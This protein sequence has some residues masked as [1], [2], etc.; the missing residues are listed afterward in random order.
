MNIQLLFLFLS[1]SL[2]LLKTELIGEVNCNDA[3]IYCV[4]DDQ[5]Y[6]IDLQAAIDAVTYPGSKIYVKAG[7]Y[8]IDT[9]QI[10]DRNTV[11]GSQNDPIQILPF[12]NDDVF[13]QDDCSNSTR[14]LEQ[15]E[16]FYLEG[17]A[18]WRFSNGEGS[19]LTFRTCENDDRSKSAHV[20]SIGQGV[21]GVTL[22]PFSMENSDGHAGDFIR[23]ENK[24]TE[25]IEIVG[26]DF[27][28]EMNG[29]SYTKFQRNGIFVLETS[30][31]LDSSKIALSDFKN[32]WVHECSFLG[33]SN[34]GIVVM[35]SSSLTVD[36]NYFTTN[37]EG[38]GT[39]GE[40]NMISLQLSSFVKIE[41]NVFDHVSGERSAKNVVKLISSA[42]EYHTIQ[43]VYF[44]HNLYNCYYEDSLFEVNVVGSELAKISDLRIQNNYFVGTCRNEEESYPIVGIIDQNNNRV[45][46][47][48][49]SGNAFQRNPL[50]LCSSTYHEP[51]FNCSLLENRVL[52]IPLKNSDEKPFPFFQ[53]LNTVVSG[54]G[55]RPELPIEDMMS[56]PRDLHAPTIGPF[57]FPNECRWNNYDPHLKCLECFGNWDLGKNCSKCRNHYFDANN[58]C[59][60]CPSNF[61]PTSD[62][63]KCSG[64]WNISTECEEC[65]NHYVGFNCLNCD[66]GWFK[67]CSECQKHWDLSRDC[68]FC[69]KNWDQKSKC[70]KC[71]GNWDFNLNCS[72][73]RNFYIDNENDCK[74][75][76][77]EFNKEKDCTQNPNHP[78]EPPVQLIGVGLALGGVSFVCCLLVLSFATVAIIWVGKSFNRNFQGSNKD[79]RMKRESKLLVMQGAIMQEETA[80]NE[81]SFMIN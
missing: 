33:V 11:D 16:M 45:N 55:D 64:N 37:S 31:T 24:N 59:G 21:T 53:P 14:V 80:I 35:E 62:C 48:S 1:F 13:F 61:D 9:I 32:V 25:G 76:P 34:N 3:L 66:G 81:D 68:L 20:I 42:T 60:S 50:T 73:C 29:R 58:N 71:K 79:V 74:T 41:N 56:F 72:E 51:S 26:V 2:C 15:Y 19:F 69:K 17:V 30:D 28:F 6:G 40:I 47:S 8:L 67:D 57:E 46:E 38:T 44:Q 77:P 18:W 70:T 27:I 22:G 36:N 39:G 23:L 75:C 65:R 78:K 10:T 43:S 52:D 63:V 5:P 54:I 49:I 12:P 4:G 7:S